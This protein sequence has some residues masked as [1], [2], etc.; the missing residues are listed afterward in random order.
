MSASAR[1]KRQAAF[2]P[3]GPEGQAKIEASRI[4]IAGCGALGTHLASHLARAGVGTI[5]LVDRDFVELHNLQRQCLFDEEDARLGLPKVEAAKTK[6]R[7]ANS[8]IE[9]EAVS[10]EISAS[11][12]VA[13]MH[14]VDL[15]LDGT[16][17]F[18]TRFILNDAAISQKKPWIYGACIGSDGMQMTIVPGTTACLRCVFDA[19]PPAGSLPTCDSAGVLSSAVGVV[20]S[21]QANEAIKILSGNTSA[22]RRGLLTIDL[23]SGSFRTL[24]TDALPESTQCKTCILH[25]YDFLEGLGLSQT[26]S[27]CGRNAVHVA[28]GKPTALGLDALA[29]RLSKLGTVTQNRF[30]LKFEIQACTL[31]I[32]P[33]GRVIVQGT[34]DPARARAL[35]AQYIGH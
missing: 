24:N 19:P 12:A 22:L 13:L 29:R 16:D 25:K 30:L 3:I 7:A 8:H 35:Y 27:L 14:D 4:L 10:T 33:D 20:A 18:E 11:N 31:S 34:D 23:W 5:R 28:P 6:L 1:Y 17:N 9:I 15:I 32:F 21:I 26:T 2:P